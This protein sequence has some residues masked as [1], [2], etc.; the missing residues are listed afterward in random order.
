M[1]R[2]DGF[3]NIGLLVGTA[4]S[5]IILMN[6]GKFACFGLQ[7]GFVFLG[8]LYIALFLPQTSPKNENLENFKPQ[9]EGTSL[10]SR[11]KRENSAMNVCMIGCRITSKAKIN[12]F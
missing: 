11:L 1:T 5:P 6:L 3:E 10:Q 9:Q 8:A 12:I 7:V 4:L 2:F